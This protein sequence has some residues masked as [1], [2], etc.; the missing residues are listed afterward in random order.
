MITT[1]LDII[2]RR[3]LIDNGMPIHYYLEG[4]SHSSTCLRELSFDTLQIYNSKNLS[5]D[6]TGAIDMPSDFDDDIA[7]CIPAGQRLIQLPKQDWITP[8]RI[9]D[10]VSGD[11]VPYTDQDNVNNDRFFG[12]EV[13]GWSWFWNVNSYG[14][15]TG[16]FFGA[17]GGTNSGYK[18][19]RERRQIQMSENFIGT[20]VVLIYASD[21][22]SVDNATQITPRAFACITSFINWKRSPN[23]DNDNSPEGRSF[24][25]QKRLLRARNDDLTPTDIKNIV[26][27]NFHASIKN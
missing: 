5:V 4:L 13:G 11:F 24:Y 2:T 17:S 21:G 22:Q 3:W 15:P 19:V 14:E 23:K 1:S 20:N 8:L 27:K 16:R 6:D 10:A 18:V 26:R 7:V 9:H 25:N 12:F